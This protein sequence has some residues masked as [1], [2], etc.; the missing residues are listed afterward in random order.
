MKK[1]INL[2]L[3]GVT[4]GIP[5]MKQ[6]RNL[7]IILTVALFLTACGGGGGTSPTMGTDEPEMGTDEPEMDT[8]EP[9]MDSDEPEMD[10]GGGTSNGG[11]G[12]TLPPP[13][14]SD[15]TIMDAIKAAQMAVMAIGPYDEATQEDVNDAQMKITALNNLITAVEDQESVAEDIETAEGLQM[16]VDTAKKFVDAFADARTAVAALGSYPYDEATKAQVDAAQT[17]VNALSMLILNPLEG[18][19][20]D[21]KTKYIATPAVELTP[22]IQDARAFTHADVNTAATAQTAAVTAEQNFD[23]KADADSIAAFRDGATLSFAMGVSK[24]ITRQVKADLNAIEMEIE[25][26]ERQ[27]QLAERAKE[28]LMAEATALRMEKTKLD[29]QLTEAQGKEAG[30]QT[31]VD[32]LQA[33]YDAL[34]ID[35]DYASDTVTYIEGLI[36]NLEAEKISAVPARLAEIEMEIADIKMDV[37]PFRYDL[38]SATQVEQKTYSEVQMLE[39]STRMAADDKKTELDNKKTEL[40]ETQDDITTLPTQIATKDGEITTKDGE[41]T[42]ADGHIDAINDILEPLEPRLATLQGVV[43]DDVAAIENEKAE[44]VF[45]MLKSELKVVSEDGVLIVDQ[46]AD[47]LTNGEVIEAADK[48]DD[49]DNVFARATVPT[50]TMT[51]EEIARAGDDDGVIDE[52]DEWVF[53]SRSI[54]NADDTVNTDAHEPVDFR[55]GGNDGGLGLPRNHPAIAL[56]GL[57][58]ADFDPRGSDTVGSSENHLVFYNGQL[59]GIEGTLYCDRRSNCITSSGRF[60]DGWYFTPVVYSGRFSGGAKGYSTEQARYIDS[61]GD[62]TYELVSYVDYGMW[63][64]GADDDPEDPLLLLRRATLVGPS[65]SPSSLDFGTDGS[66]TD[67]S[68]TYSGDARGLSA[69]TVGTGDDAVTAS[70]HFEADVTLNATFGTAPELGGTID[71]FRPVDGQGDG[72][73]DTGWRLE[74]VPASIDT[75]DNSLTYSRKAYI[76]NN[77]GSWNAEPYGA[78][79]ERP[80]GFYGGFDAT[81]PN[82][83]GT[84]VGAAAGVYSAEKD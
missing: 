80:A 68:A 42:T 84:T 73:V 35:A 29:N 57:D 22:I 21:D 32:A 59:K 43:G 63:L 13:T 40:T 51:F 5:L 58:V 44:L 49:S 56:S 70:G 28:N 72:H 45:D 33:E 14:D 65:V 67:P 3:T 48:L 76:T 8:D 60:G 81:F 50:G 19:S 31:M 16:T 10:S 1:L 39:A 52:L 83:E 62:G 55:N 53:Q 78:S 26:I 23:T 9:E 24:G 66:N 64:E 6:Y 77:G 38:P 17:A 75:N 34:E 7:F 54:L 79:G 74:L 25:K 41:V 2:N 61:D 27:L 71:N 15:Q 47:S 12:G 46:V 30:L 69:R 82:S 37:T 36:A 4:R 20:D 18:L 11:G